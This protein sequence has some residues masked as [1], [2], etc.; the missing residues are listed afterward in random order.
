MMCWSPLE[1]GLLKRFS[2][3]RPLMSLRLLPRSALPPRRRCRPGVWCLD[4]TGLDRDRFEGS[5][6][7]F[8]CPCRPK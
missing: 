7:T 4:E 5:A 8:D 1:Q 2:P 3:L 6:I